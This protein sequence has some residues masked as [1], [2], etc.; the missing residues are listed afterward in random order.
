MRVC[1]VYTSD[2]LAPRHTDSPSAL[3]PKQRA[4]L[5]TTRTARCTFLARTGEVGDS[6]VRE[7]GERRG[8]DVTEPLLY[9]RAG[10]HISVNPIII[11]GLDQ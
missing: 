1:H 10:K 2:I 8:G 4:A 3:R 7:R 11:E 9:M 6:S 5:R